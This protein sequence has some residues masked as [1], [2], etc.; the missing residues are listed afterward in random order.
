MQRPRSLSQP[1]PSNIRPS[2][3]VIKSAKQFSQKL[4]STASRIEPIQEEEHRTSPAPNY[5]MSTASSR[6]RSTTPTL[7]GYPVPLPRP[8]STFS[9][10]APQPPK[11]LTRTSRYGDDDSDE[12]RDSDEETQKQQ[13]KIKSYEKL[14]ERATSSLAESQTIQVNLIN[15]LKITQSKLKDNEKRL[16][17]AEISRARLWKMWFVQE[18]QNH[19]RLDH[20]IEKLRDS[21]RYLRN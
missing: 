3:S 13:E 6:S 15:E 21:T 12:D 14:L 11:P 20:L 9:R 19:E 5:L 8:S 4:N 18:E 1:T 16:F 10:K 17:D 7:G 2:S